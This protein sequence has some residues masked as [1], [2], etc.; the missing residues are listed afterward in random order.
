MLSNVNPQTGIRYGVASMNSLADW[1][2]D[3]FFYNGTND[4]A[5]AALEDWK[6]E[7]PTLV[8]DDEAIQNFWDR[9]YMAEEECYS[10]TTDGMRLELSYLGGAALVFVLESPVISV[11]RLCSPCIPNAGD[12]DAREENGAECY[13]LPPEWYAT[14]DERSCSTP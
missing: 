2:W 5:E 11:A 8:D 9:E 4:T 7:N 14:D 1:V 13:G 6:T 12:L 3:E 10:L